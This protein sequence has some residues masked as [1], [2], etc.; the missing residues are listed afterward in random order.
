LILLIFENSD[1][2]PNLSWNTD[3]VLSLE[4]SGDDDSWRN[5]NGYSCN[6]YYKN[7][8]W[9]L[10]AEDYP[11][12]DNIPAT[13]ACPSVCNYNVYNTNHAVVIIGSVYKTNE[14]LPQDKR[15]STSDGKYFWVLRNS[16]GPGWGDNGHFYV[17]RDVND[18][19]FNG[20]ACLLSIYDDIS[21]ITLNIE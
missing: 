20:N 17:E 4:H 13:T 11:S 6:D 3:Y 10:E 19:R 9:C 5:I 8:S 7:P 2:D 12:E 21:Y 1:T 15:S 18:E 16:W 14:S